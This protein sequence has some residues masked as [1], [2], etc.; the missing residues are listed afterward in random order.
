MPA[1][2]TTG[3]IKPAAVLAMAEA[4]IPRQAGAVKEHE[5]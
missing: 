4:G 3:S 2:G 5:N 1:P